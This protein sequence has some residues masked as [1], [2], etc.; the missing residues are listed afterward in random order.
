MAALALIVAGCAEQQAAPAPPPAAI[1]APLTSDQNFVDRASLGTGTEVELGRLARSRAVSPA[2]RAFADRIIADHRQAHTRL[3]T[4]ERRIQMAAAPV[5][6]PPNN[7]TAL[8][9]LNFDRQ[10][11]TGLGDGIAMPHAKNSAVK[12]ATVLFAKSQK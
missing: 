11:S 5:S 8:S 3:G 7:L 1:S 9:G 6:P 12:E 4:I 2:V 10:T